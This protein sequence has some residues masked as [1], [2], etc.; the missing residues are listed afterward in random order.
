MS[1]SDSDL[2]AVIANRISEYGTAIALANPGDI[3]SAVVRDMNEHS[4]LP[5][6]KLVELFDRRVRRRLA[7]VEKLKSEDGITDAELFDAVYRVAAYELR[8]SLHG[9][10]VYQTHWSLKL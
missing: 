1:P 6:D 8:S 5:T 7:V 2:R 4:L 10:R 9:Y 3:A